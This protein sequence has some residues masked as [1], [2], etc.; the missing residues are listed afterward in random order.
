[1]SVH[2]SEVRLRLSKEWLTAVEEHAD[3]LETTHIGL[4]L[5]T[6]HERACALKRLERLRTRVE[7]AQAALDAHIAEHGC[8]FV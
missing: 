6:L 3:V 2:S 7:N 5:L 1:M 8:S 4:P